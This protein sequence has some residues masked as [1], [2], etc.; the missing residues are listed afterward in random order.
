MRQAA[1]FGLSLI[2]LFFAAPAAAHAVNVTSVAMY[3]DAGDY[4][5]GGQQKL[6]TPA[7]SSITVG[8]N[9]GDLS[10]SVNGGPDGDWFTFEF[11]APPDHVL[12]PGVYTDAERA[13]FR[14]AGHPG[15]DIGGSGRGCNEI[16]GRFEV[17]D[18]AVAGDGTLQRLWIV[19]EQHC[20]G[21][22]KA[23]FGE[24]RIAEPVPDAPAVAATSIVRWPPADPGGSGTAVPVTLVAGAPTQ[25]TGASIAGENGGDFVKRLDDC[26]GKTLGAGG[27]C[28]VWVRFVPTAA[29]TRTG[30]LDIAD[31]AGH[32]YRTSLQGFSYGG[33]TKAVM[34]SDSGDYIGQ[35]Q[36]W[37]YS[38]ANA[39]LAASGSRQGV[40]FGIS[41]NNGDWWTAEFT[42]PSGD[43]IAPGTYENASRASFSGG[44]A[45]MDVSGNGRGCNTIS[46]RFTITEAGYDSGGHLRTLGVKFEQHCEG[47]APAFRGELDYRM[48]DKTPPAPWMVAGGQ[49]PAAPPGD[50]QQVG[51][52]QP[53]GPSGLVTLTPTR[54]SIVFG[55]ATRVRGSVKVNGALAPR[56]PVEIQAAA[57]PYTSYAP[58]KTI[59]TDSKGRFAFR[60]KPDRNTRYRAVAAGVM[61]KQRTVFVDVRTRFVRRAL[62]GGRYRETV[63]VRGPRDLPYA[64]RRI[65]LYKLSHHGKRARRAAS[66]RLRAAGRAGRV[67][68]SAVLRLRSRRAHTLACLPEP[69]P[70]AWGRAYPIDKACGARVLVSRPGKRAARRVAPPAGWLTA[71]P[72]P[73]AAGGLSRVR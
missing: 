24:V 63:F 65:W 70:D 13:P 73:A 58:L 34:T 59:A 7:N 21:G 15:I 8:G 2:A 51:G 16:E 47:Q 23:L 55:A 38:P 12:A 52:P 17:K 60:V 72:G 9:T 61:S 6:F 22:T 10:V 53:G 39:T 1:A 33:T 3:S 69:T 31:S 45:G 54:R 26:S 68:G 62:G 57:F 36:T 50:G 71:P 37:S 28:E 20:E 11:A 49:G 40:Y 5:G 14:T 27:T 4:I 30:V 66:A 48:G 42:A 18:L 67:R 41:G 32:H 35:G 64:G 46:G 56:T 19:Y 25:I 29:G 43:I 44:G